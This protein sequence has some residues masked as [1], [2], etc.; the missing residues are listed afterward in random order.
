MEGKKVRKIITSDGWLKHLL[1]VSPSNHAF[2][3]FHH[4]SFFHFVRTNALKTLDAREH[5]CSRQWHNVFAF[6]LGI[7]PSVHMIEFSHTI[8]L[9]L[10]CLYSRS[11]QRLQKKGELIIWQDRICF[12]CESMF[13]NK[14]WYL[15]R[16]YRPP[17]LPDIN[18]KIL[19]TY[20]WLK[21]WR[22]PSEESGVSVLSYCTWL[23]N[24]KRWSEN[25]STVDFIPTETICGAHCVVRI[26]FAYP[27]CIYG[28]LDRIGLR[29][30]NPRQLHSTS[31]KCSLVLLL[32]YD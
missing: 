6:P 15:Q 27:L 5:S 29:I 24:T 7:S 19:G 4:V 8:K 31:C 21:W 13:I 14:A 22:N 17:Q 30:L 28:C 20:L 11:F 25:S 1:I 9:I 18:S 26:V 12:V 16:I 10:S 3:L 32:W 23:T 2:S